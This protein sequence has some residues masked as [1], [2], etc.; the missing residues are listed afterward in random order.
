MKEIEIIIKGQKYYLD[1]ERYLMEEEFRLLQE[2]PLIPSFLWKTFNL[3]D[4]RLNQIREQ[5]KKI[6]DESKDKVHNS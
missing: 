5:L 3:D 6:R 4:T 2:R 1:F